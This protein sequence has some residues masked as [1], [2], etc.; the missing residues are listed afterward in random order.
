MYKFKLMFDTALKK[1][2]HIKRFEKI[3]KNKS[4]THRCLTVFKRT[5]KGIFFIISFIFISLLTLISFILF[6]F[7]PKSILIFILSSLLPLILLVI[8][9]LLLLSCLPFLLKPLTLFKFINVFPLL[10]LLSSLLHW[11]PLSLFLLL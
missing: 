8:L 3:E 9:L 2:K 10:L 5:F 6:L 4:K 7:D 1:G 11:L